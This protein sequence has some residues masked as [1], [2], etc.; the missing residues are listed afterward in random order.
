[1]NRE[2]FMKTSRLKICRNA[3]LLA[4][5]LRGEAYAQREER[6]VKENAR[7]KRLVADQALELKKLEEE[8][9]A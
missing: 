7:L 6:L 9:F 1:M 4:G 2:R 3:P 8:E 5:L